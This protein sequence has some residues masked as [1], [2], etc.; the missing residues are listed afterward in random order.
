[1]EGSDQRPLLYV[2]THATDDPTLASLPF[3]VATG[4]GT[5][6]IDCR[7]ALLG[8]AAN[9]VKPGMIDAVQGVGFPALRELWE[10]VRDF[11]I[12]VYV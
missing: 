6:E 1:M 11:D 10:K 8:E 5:A 3:L 2:S 9:L 4:A 7:I 12:P